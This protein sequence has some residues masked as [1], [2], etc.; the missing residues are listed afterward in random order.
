MDLSALKA[1]LLNDP[2]ELGYGAALTAG[3]VG[4]AAALLN[5]VGDYS[6]RRELGKIPLDALLAW[7]GAGFYGRMAD[8]AAT[9]N[10]PL[11]SAALV[12]I[13]MFKLP[14]IQNFALDLPANQALASACL[15]NGIINQAELDQ[16]N[17]LAEQS[18][19]RAESLWGIGT[20]VTWEQVAQALAL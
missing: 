11:R 14:S 4:A 16:L 13:D 12:F 20:T 5:A 18:G 19:S 1:E 6:V 8:I 10:H 15:T 17:A 2:D 3:D 9:A 7:A